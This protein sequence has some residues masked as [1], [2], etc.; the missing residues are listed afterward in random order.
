MAACFLL[1]APFRAAATMQEITVTGIGVHEYIEQAQILAADY[2]KKRA[3]Y[4]IAQK[5][6]VDDLEKKLQ[7]MNAATIAQSVRGSRVLDFKREGNVLYTKT[8]VTVMDA[9]LKRALKVPVTQNT[10]AAHGAGVLV[11]PVFKQGEQLLLWDKKNP[12]RAPIRRTALTH[13]NQSVIV[14]LGDAKDM[15]EIGTDNILHAKFD[16]FEGL[17]T[18]Y[19]AKEVLVVLFSAPEEESDISRVLV[20]RIYKGGNKPE[21][22]DI[23]SKKG[24]AMSAKYHDIATTVI[25]IAAERAAATAMEQRKSRAK[26]TAQKL[27]FRFTTMGEYG[28]LT[29]LLRA[30]EIVKDLEVNTIA[31]QEVHGV[32]YHDNKARELR[33]YFDK[34]G[35]KLYEE[36]DTWVVS[37]R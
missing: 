7:R 32:L 23:K 37:L 14:P 1:A 20:N 21:I 11:I 15:A 16:A 34:K 33:A 18:R 24:S 35:I 5:W 28:T 27:V 10:P 29:E 17:L 13:S 31:L 26:L 2:A 3:L 9:P 8:V 12:L 22:L 4:E 25:R 19:A 6:H 30:C 36:G